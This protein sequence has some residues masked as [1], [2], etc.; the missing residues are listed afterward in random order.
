MHGTPQVHQITPPA[1]SAARKLLETEK[2]GQ[3][4]AQAV[5]DAAARSSNEVGELRYA[6]RNKFAELAAFDPE[7]GSVQVEFRGVVLFVH[8]QSEQIQA[9]GCDIAAL[10]SPQD[11]L[12]VICLA[13]EAQREQDIER[14]V[15][16]RDELRMSTREAA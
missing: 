6:L 4:K 12:A 10:L 7:D 9:N 11:R 1:I 5:I 3:A 13:E 14:A 8:I 16:A 15:R 2:A